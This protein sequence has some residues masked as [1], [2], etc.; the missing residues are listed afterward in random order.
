MRFM[1][2]LQKTTCLRWDPRK[3]MKQTAEKKAT[4]MLVTVTQ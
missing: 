1:L 3:Y 4:G 2:I